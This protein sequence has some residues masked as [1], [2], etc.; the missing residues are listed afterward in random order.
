MCRLGI[1]LDAVFAQ[2]EAAKTLKLKLKTDKIQIKRKKRSQM[3]TI[4]IHKIA[5][6]L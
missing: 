6:N 3:M 4:N 1:V 2:V 5:H